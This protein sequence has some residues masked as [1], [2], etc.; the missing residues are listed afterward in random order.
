MQRWYTWLLEVK[1]KAEEKRKEEEHQTL[2]SRWCRRRS[3]KIAQ[4]HKNR[5]V[6]EEVCKC[7][8]RWKEMPRP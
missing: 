4:N 6:G 2:V 8:K 3:R 7:W 5:Q 1:K